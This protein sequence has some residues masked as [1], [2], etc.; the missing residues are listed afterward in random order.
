MEMSRS[1]VKGTGTDMWFWKFSTNG[2]HGRG[3]LGRDESMLIL[4]GKGGVLGNFKLN[5][6]HSFKE[7][8]QTLKIFENCE[9]FFLNL[10][11]FFF[12]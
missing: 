12:V 8:G 11:I 10:Y 4:C 7:K 2:K 9:L 3:G 5:E 1:F 6:Q